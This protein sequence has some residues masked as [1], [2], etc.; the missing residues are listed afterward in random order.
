MLNYLNNI[1]NYSNKLN[2][3]V[4]LTPNLLTIKIHLNDCLPFIKA[5]VYPNS[6]FSDHKTFLIHFLNVDLP[7]T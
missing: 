6:N 7:F 2:I 1:V 4:P 5:Q 3:I